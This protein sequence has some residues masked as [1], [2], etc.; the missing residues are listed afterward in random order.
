MSSII[1]SSAEVS[2]HDFVTQQKRLLESELRAEEDEVTVVQNNNANGGG[3]QMRNDDGRNRDGGFFLRN[4]D[5]IDTSVGLYGRTV[6]SFGSI[7]EPSI[8]DNDTSGSSN[9]S[10]SSSKLLPAHRLTVGD[11]VQI[12][13]NNGKGFQKKASKG[14]VISAVDD[15]SISVALFNADSN[16]KQSSSD[17]SRSQTKK[18]QG[19]KNR[20]DDDYV[21]DEMLG[22]N[23][24]YSLIPQSNIE[25]HNKMLAAL[26]Q[27]AKHGVNHPI[28][29]AIIMEAFETN[30]PKHNTEMSR[31]RIET[32]ES[33]CGLAS[34]KLDYSQKEAIVMALYSKSPISLIHGPP[35][36]GRYLVSL[37]MKFHCYFI[38]A[39]TSHVLLNPLIIAFA[40]KTTT[41]AELIRCAVHNMGWKVL[42]TAPSNVA[43]DNVLDRIMSIENEKH[44]A[45][46]GKRG[47]KKSSTN[48]KVKAVRLGHPARIQHS[49]QKYSLESLVQ[50]SEGTEIVKD[51]RTELNEYLR[52]LSN[53]KSRPSEKREAYREMKSLKKEIRTREEKVV[54]QILRD[55]N[56]VLATNV[57][58][59]SSL[60]RRMLDTKGQPICFDLVIIDEAAQ[61]LEASCWISLLRG[62]RA[63]LAGDH[64]QLPPTI[65]CSVREVQQGLGRTLF[66]RLMFSYKKSNDGTSSCRSKMLEVQYRMHQDISDWASKAMY[67]GKLISHESVRERQLLTLPVVAEK[68]NNTNQI[69]DDDSDD[70][71]DKLERVTLMLVDTTGCDM[72]EKANEAGSRFNE[73]EANI[74]VSHVHS[75]IKLGLRAEDIAV[76]TPYNGQVELLRRLLLPVVPKLEIRS[77]D[78]FQGGEKEAVVLS[79][80]RSSDRGGQNGIG[81]LRDERRLNVA[82]TRAK[83]HCAVICDCETVSKNKFIKG[84][85]NWLEEKG[86]YR[87]GAEYTTS[88]ATVI[89]SEGLQTKIS[90]VVGKVNETP[91]EKQH[92]IVKGMSASKQSLPS[93]KK[94][95]TKSESS[96]SEN[97]VNVETSRFELMERIKSFSESGKT[98][99]ELNLS[100]D[101]VFDAVV[102]Q[103]LAKQLGLE[104]KKDSGTNNLVLTVLRDIMSMTASLDEAPT[105]EESPPSPVVTTSQFTQLDIDDE[106]S[107]SSNEVDTCDAPNNN[108]LR[109]LALE[110]E[111][112]QSEL[113]QPVTKPATA[114]KKKKK[115]G[116][117]KVS[118]AKNPQKSDEKED[119]FSDL[120]FLD[121]Q[122]EKSQSSHGRK[123]DGKGKGYRSIVSDISLHSRNNNIIN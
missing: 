66:E 123:V 36:T 43:V 34:S 6:I 108:L 89:S 109:E 4:I 42:V 76:I 114:S 33:E 45:A 3:Q 15:M 116:K 119:N 71:Q 88:D 93:T 110:R 8:S 50:S 95:E 103:E 47:S 37:L 107:V 24:P 115:K 90:L 39:S 104:C 1:S 70:G 101:S 61:A 67:N 99:D 44:D 102:A 118:G 84:L 14:G 100:P 19:K 96:P 82:V 48:K 80:V 68:V 23:A 120:D 122:I 97:E 27:L 26:D 92:K 49:I 75:L 53:T 87:S 41:V 98:G 54:G 40:G 5:I 60:L 13:P 17:K 7:N 28:A 106:S 25:V 69:T 105:I 64:K 74:V 20:E 21:D 72:H 111:K 35:G 31:S 63:V 91:T 78:G 11:E 18:I 94:A 83:R 12:L 81:F 73:G 38:F 79:L 57:G 51:C 52:T 16:R 2:L 55:S 10:S 22:G 29:G 113:P 121:A 65:K 58:A 32:L 77:V 9:K 56:V 112:R 46:P 85:V 86:E 117:S 30:N 62:K 59:A